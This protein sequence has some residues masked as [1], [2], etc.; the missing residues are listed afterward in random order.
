[1]NKIIPATSLLLL[2]SC[3]T[4]N[5]KTTEIT[6][7]SSAASSTSKRMSAVKNKTATVTNLANVAPLRFHTVLQMGAGEPPA[8][9]IAVSADAK[10]VMEEGILPKFVRYLKRGVASWYGPRFHGK[11]TANGEIFDMYAMTA[12]HKTLPIP[13]YAQITNLENRKSVVV[14]INDRGPYIGNRLLD[15]SYAAAKKLDMQ[16]GGLGKVEIKAV[17]SPLAAEYAHIPAKSKPAKEVYLQVASFGSQ[18]KALKFKNKIA[19]HHLPKPKIR[20]AKYKTAT[21]YKVQFGPLHSTE[22]ADKLYEQLAEIGITDPQVV[23]EK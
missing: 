18:K 4:Q 23:T 3:S 2:C 11:K 7:P 10:P 17:P 9:L 8:E 22:K 14:R 16:D 21:V 15:L 1:M 20:T 5:L 6:V 19:A 13:S 12:A